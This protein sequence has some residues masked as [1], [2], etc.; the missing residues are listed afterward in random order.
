[1][2]LQPKISVC[3][4]NNCKTLSITDITGLLSGDGTWGTPDLA[5]ADVDTATISVLSPNNSAYID[6]DVTIALTADPLTTDVFL[7]DIAYSSLNLPTN[8]S[9]GIYKFTYTITDASN[10]TYTYN[11]TKVITCVSRCCVDGMI[12]E[13]PNKM[14][15]DCCD[16]LGFIKDIQ[17]AESIMLG[18]D[19]AGACGNLEAVNTQ[20]TTLDRICLNQG[21]SC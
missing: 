21:C 17:I 10:N 7:V 14:Q 4:E 18:L 6:F 2:A 16:T 8:L 3:T 12:A 20:L 1:M 13:L 11:L 19:L 15:C 5:R 9:N